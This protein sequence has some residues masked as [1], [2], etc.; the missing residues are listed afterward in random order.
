MGME[1]REELSVA[2]DKNETLDGF[3][4][5]LINVCWV[6]TVYK[7]WAKDSGPR[8]DSDGLDLQA[9]EGD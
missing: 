8:E 9:T 5:R 3:G 4:V 2:Q 1:S 6:P 7:H